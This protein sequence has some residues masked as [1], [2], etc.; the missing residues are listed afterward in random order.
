MIFKLEKTKEKILIDIKEKDNVVLSSTPNYPLT[1]L[2]FHY[3]INRTRS[4]MNITKSLETTSEFYYVV[5]PFETQI[6][7]YDDSIYNLTKVYLNLKSSEDNENFK[8]HTWYKIWEILFSFDIANQKNLNLG[9]ISKSSNI[10][11]DSVESYRKKL[12]TNSKTNT[13]IATIKQKEVQPEMSNKISFIPIILKG[14]QDLIIADVEYEPK[15][16]NMTEQETYQLFVSEIYN[17][18]SN[19]NKGGSFIVKIWDTYTNVTIKLI[20]ILTSYFSESYIY[21]PFFSRQTTSERYIICKEFNKTITTKELKIFENIIKDM[22]SKQWVF[23][24]FPSI[25]LNHSYLNLWKYQNNKIV[26]QQQI[27]INKLVRYIK[28]NVYFGDDYHQYREKQISN[29]QWWVETFFPPSN[30]LVVKNKEEINKQNKLSIDRNKSDI[31][32]LASLLIIN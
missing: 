28:E 12:I 17:A 13:N 11:K 26:N 2:G 3:F 19:L 7:N 25:E 31:D 4:A 20:W 10:I 23:D 6:L 21:K 27:I 32:K 15:V 22:D 18:L 8:S 14:S 1:S 29:I 5:N 30:N 24:V 9:I 16:Q